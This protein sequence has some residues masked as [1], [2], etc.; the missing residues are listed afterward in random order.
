MSSETWTKP[1]KNLEFPR[2]TDVRTL[3]LLRQDSGYPGINGNKV[4]S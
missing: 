3:D 1:L 4:G 2:P